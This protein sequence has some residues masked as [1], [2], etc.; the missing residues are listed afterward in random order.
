MRKSFDSLDSYHMRQAIRRGVSSSTLF[1]HLQNKRNPKTKTDEESIAETETD[2]F[3]DL[4]MHA[5]SALRAIVDSRWG[6]KGERK[7]GP[8]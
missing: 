6:L 3:G 7:D 5:E 8:N 2:S 1:E 4:G